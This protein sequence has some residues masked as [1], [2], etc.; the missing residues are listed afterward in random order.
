MSVGLLTAKE[1]VFAVSPQV[2]EDQTPEATL[3]NE[4]VDLREEST[5]TFV[6]SDK[7]YQTIVYSMPVHYFEDG[8]W[9]EIDN[10]LIDDSS[11]S[12]EEVQQSEDSVNDD[13]VLG[14]KNKSGSNRIK[15]AKKV[16]KNN[17]GSLTYDKYKIT[18]GFDDATNKSNGV[19]TQNEMNDDPVEGVLNQINQE[20][21]YSQVTDGIDLKYD[22]DS[23]SVKENIII[24]K[25]Q[26]IYEFEFNYKT[27]NL[28]LSINEDGEIEAKDG[29]SLIFKMPKPFMYDSNE[30][31]SD[32]VHYELIQK[33][34]KKYVIK[35]V[36]DQQW[37]N[38]DERVYP[39]TIDPVIQTETTK[40]AIDTTFITSSMPTTNHFDK[41]ELLVGKEASQYGNCRTLVK[42]ALPSLNRGDMIV[43]AELNIA[44]YNH[45]FYA[46]STPDLQVNAHMATSSWVIDEVTWNTC[47]SFESMVLDY[48]YIKRA[49][50]VSSAN[51]K[52]FD[53]TNAVKRWYE[54][55]ANN[56]IVL[57]SYN[58]SGT[59]ASTGVK[60]YLW[61]ERY[62][63]T[64]KSYPYIALTYRNNKGI[65][66]Y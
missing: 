13:E 51:W 11:S 61:P 33:G 46:S 37:M 30:Q 47:P 23:L 36:A 55:T 65:E 17:L 18:W 3:L 43:D 32:L 64:T 26:D 5:K 57:K 53:I 41:L 42:F 8:T 52:K 16:H 10:T 50:T 39:L 40:S 15:F 34:D 60:G 48:D 19:Y 4:D 49:D 24:H 20:I 56:G 9:K 45:S 31:Y 27:K 7:S 25:K 62:N 12:N 59:Y 63:S 38:D 66:D 44:S 54:G 1:K 29:D 14:Y 28:T 58:E 21:C 2:D 6:M 22:I 35:I